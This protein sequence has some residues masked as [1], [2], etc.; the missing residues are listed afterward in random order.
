MEHTLFIDL[1]EAFFIPAYLLYAVWIALGLRWIISLGQEYL[2]DVKLKLIPIFIY[3]IGITIPA[4]I[5]LSHY[6]EQDK[7]HYYFAYDL[8]QATLDTMESNAIYFAE[9]D[10]FIFPVYYLQIIEKKRPDI[11]VITRGDM[12]K[13]W[14]YDAYTHHNPN[15]ITIPQF[16]QDKI[17]QYKRYLDKK[18]REFVILNLQH[19]PIYY[20]FSP[21]PELDQNLYRIRTGM[22]YQIVSTI[23]PETVELGTEKYRSPPRLYRYRGKPEDGLSAD[24]WTQFSINQFSNFHIL[25]GDYYTIKH[26]FQKAVDEYF[27]ALRIKP[28]SIE[29]YYHLSILYKLLGDVDRE[30]QA[31]ENVLLLEPNHIEAKRKLDTINS[32]PFTN[33]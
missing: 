9:D 16:E 27:I 1:R 12:Y 17:Y 33:P 23:P 28:N 2:L 18:V 24:D 11:T 20:Y 10:P 19:H 5:L 21:P 15:Q 3:I 29:A 26:K 6:R 13:W 14:F 22:L 30:K 8:G 31:F 32:T 7:S 25:Q 4:T